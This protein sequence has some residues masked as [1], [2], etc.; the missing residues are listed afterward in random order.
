MSSALLRK[1]VD[2]TEAMDSA[3]KKSLLDRVNDCVKELQLKC[4][5]ERSNSLV[6]DEATNSFLW[7]LEAVFIHGLSNS[8][9]KATSP[10]AS[11]L[12]SFSPTSSFA[13]N[14]GRSDSSPAVPNPSFWEFVLVFLHRDIID[15]INSLHLIHTDVGRC[16]AWLRIALNEG[17]LQ[18]FL[19]NMTLK[20]NRRC[21]K[22]FYRSSS[23]LRDTEKCDIL[24]NYL[25]GIE[26]LDFRLVIN[27]SFLNHWNSGPLSLVGLWVDENESVQ[28]GVD[29]AKNI[30][31]KEFQAIPKL[32]QRHN[33][34]IAGGGTPPRFYSELDS[35]LRRQPPPL[36][37]EDDALRIILSS[38][39]RPSPSPQVPPPKAQS[40]S[41]SQFP[42]PPPKASSSSPRK[43]PSTKTKKSETSS[44][45]LS[46]LLSTPDLHA[47][48]TPS[49]SKPIDKSKT[50]GEPPSIKVDSPS[51]PKTNQ[52]VITTPLSSI[53]GISSEGEKSESSQPLVENE[54]VEEPQVIALTRGNLIQVNSPPDPEKMCSS[55]AEIPPA[56]MDLS[57]SS[58]EMESP[59]NERSYTDVLLKYQERSKLQN[60]TQMTEDDYSINN[61]S[62]ATTSSDLAL[63][64]HEDSDNGQQ[65]SSSRKES[66]S[67]CSNTTSVSVRSQSSNVRVVRFKNIRNQQPTCY[68]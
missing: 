17:L 48:A 57:V 2:K 42:L 11:L 41:S 47:V 40:S 51:S 54:V 35:V 6:N 62:A 49:D 27:N 18:S 52:S 60:P 29:V 34:S 21:L 14:P 8:F 19:D 53:S 25:M 64:S 66:T 7:V 12:N 50:A 4:T 23:F 32:Q 28:Q 31:S 5:S 67:G 13:S 68:L 1:A 44:T 33:N 55:P 22:A 63:S 39:P 46:P 59:T 16:R 56:H 10:F 61:N 15:Q 36:L 58:I 65:G 3:L 38:S 30:E 26:L 9:L 45:Q 20:S 24:K 37:S 43:K